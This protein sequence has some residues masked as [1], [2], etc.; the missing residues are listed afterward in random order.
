[1]AALREKIHGFSNADYA[2]RVLHRL[3]IAP[4]RRNLRGLQAWFN[5]EGGDRANNAHFNL[6]GTTL[7]RPGSTSIN[8]VGVQSFKSLK[9]GVG[10][11]ARTLKNGNY[12]AILDALENGN[13]HDIANA[14]GSSPWGTSGSLLNSVLAGTPKVKAVPKSTGLQP[15]AKKSSLSS[16][17]AATAST[18]TTQ[19]AFDA[20]QGATATP[21][22]S[23]LAKNKAAATPLTRPTFS[24]GVQLPSGYAQPSS[25]GAA[26]TKVRSLSDALSTSAAA[27]AQQVSF[28]APQKA[29]V[30]AVVSK[31]AATHATRAGGGGAGAAAAVE[32]A[33]GKVGKA[34]TSENHG[35]Y[36]DRLEK[37][38]GFSGAAWCAMFTSSAVVQGGAPTSA[39]TA[40]VATVRAKAQAKDDYNFVHSGREKAG[41]LILFGNDHIG[42]VVKVKGGQFLMVAGNDSDRVNKRWVARGSGDVVRPQYGKKSR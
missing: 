39:R 19:Q 26:P 37:R 24:A 29:G 15:A 9:Q 33:L 7:R 41:D 42:M 35:A 2:E 21:L 32:Y 12:G 14:V 10:A 18:G 8:S 6:L 30:K 13:A 17:V 31:A 16:K 40:S 23:I 1:M 3:D 20:T 25:Q 27:P 5:A 36:V 38:F 28:S 34:E 11:T 4:T 22:T